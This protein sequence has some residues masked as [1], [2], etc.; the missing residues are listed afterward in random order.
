GPGHPGL[1]LRAEAP[2]GRADRGSHQGLTAARRTPRA[3]ARRRGPR[4]RTPAPEPADRRTGP[5]PDPPAAP[6]PW[7][8][9]TNHREDMTQH[10]ADRIQPA[11]PVQGEAA[12]AEARSARGDQQDWWRGAVI[13]QVY[14]RSFADANG[15]GMGDLPGVRAR[16][17][18]LAELG[19]D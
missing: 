4:R 13:Y 3:G 15:D 7:P 18:Y 9:P 19:V 5:P 14:P 12:P 2:P 1:R 17:P 11:T 10:L 6:R 16:L 8:I